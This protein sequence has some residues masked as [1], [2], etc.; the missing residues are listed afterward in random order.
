MTGRRLEKRGSAS[1]DKAPARQSAR[2]EA[3]A[4]T[5]ARAFAA[6]HAGVTMP[7]VGFDPR[8]PLAER[9]RHEAMLGEDLSDVSL[10]R[11][12]GLNGVAAMAEGRDVTLAPNVP[13]EG[14]PLRR[15][16][17]HEV[18]HVAGPAQLPARHSGPQMDGP[19]LSL[20]SVPAPLA[21]RSEFGMSLTVYFGQGSFLLGSV[22]MTALARLRDELRLTPG[23][24]IQIDGYASAEGSAALNDELSRN[25]RM[26]V[27]ALLDEALPPR[28]TVTGR[29]HG[30]AEAGETDVPGP[31]RE[32]FRA[33]H[34]RVEITVVRPPVAPATTRPTPRIL[35][36]T[37][38]FRPETDEERL[39]RILRT[40]LPE[41]NR[42]G[43]SVCGAWSDTTRRF[44]DRSLRRM[45]M[46]ENVREVLTDLGVGAMDKLPMMVIEEGLS[47]AGV[48]GQE[49]RAILS[50]VEAACQQEITP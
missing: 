18:A 16:L 7:E 47:A 37:L 11:S 39:N 44:F 9:R 22:G 24:M 27:R 31:A 34:R 1:A 45:G 26:T 23:A 12:E 49:Q 19:V 32:A 36:P 28:A 10:H 40:P 4:E 17:A 13:R 42:P 30:E 50:A 15:L 43:F 41:L 3:A 29:A 21:H 20:R 5:Y 25:R 46:G 33:R 14:A 48:E 6:R 38:P 2:A 35:R 8:L